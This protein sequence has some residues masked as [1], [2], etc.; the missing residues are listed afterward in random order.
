MKPVGRLKDDSGNSFFAIVQL[1]KEDKEGNLY[2]PVG[3]Q[4]RL[5]WKEQKK[6]FSLIPA[7]NN[8]EFVRYG[9]M[10]RNTYLNAPEIMNKYMQSKKNIKM[11]S[12]QDR[13]PVLKVTLKP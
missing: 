1:R 2:S 6:V 3:F 13:F 4:T 5:K 10:H 7:L 11:S 9:V 8:A 12:S